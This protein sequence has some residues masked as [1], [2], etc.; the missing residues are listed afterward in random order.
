M[1]SIH[2][3]EKQELP[4]FARYPLVPQILFHPSILF[5]VSAMTQILSVLLTSLFVHLS[6]SFDWREEHGWVSSTPLSLPYVGESSYSH[7]RP[8]KDQGSLYPDGSKF[9]TSSMLWES[10]RK[11]GETGNCFS[12]PLRS[13]V[14]VCLWEKLLACFFHIRLVKHRQTLSNS[15]NRHLPQFLPIGWIFILKYWWM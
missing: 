7:Q 1:P 12:F 4:H 11:M 6:F 8:P 9:L 3:R 14:K 2:T 5:N 10:D 15:S 13:E